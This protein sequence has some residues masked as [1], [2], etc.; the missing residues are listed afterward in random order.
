MNKTLLTLAF[1][2]VQFTCF[3]QA[4]VIQWKKCFG[5][6]YYDYGNSILPTPDGSYVGVGYFNSINGDVFGNHDLADF[7]IIKLSSTGTI[8]WE[9]TFGGS[10]GD[11][12]YGIQQTSDGGYIVAGFTGSNDGDVTGYHDGDGGDVW[13][14]KLSAIGD[15]IWQKS[16]GGTGNDYVT[17]ILTTSNGD[18]LVAG[19]TFSNDGDVSGNHG[20]SDCWVV[21]LSAVGDVMWQKTLGGSS[22]D[23]AYSIKPTQDG[24][25]IVAGSTLSFDGEVTGNHG[26][27]GEDAWIVKL[28]A[29]GTLVWQKTLG[30]T[31]ADTIY[32]IQTNSDGSFILAGYTI[33]NDGDVVGNHGSTDA[34]VVQL[35]G[36]G[37]LLWQKTLGGTDI[38]WANNIQLTPDGG[39]I[40]SCDA[41]STNGDVTGA[42]GEKDAWLVKLASNGSIMWQKA[43]GGTSMDGAQSVHC[44]SDGGYVFVGAS[45]SLNGNVSGNH[46][47]ADFWVVKLSADLSFNGFE[48][49]HVL[50]YPNPSH[51]ILNIQPSNNTVIDKITITDLMGKLMLM[52]NSNTT[53]VN[54]EQLASGMY[55]LE[56]VS[57]EDKFT[58]KFVKE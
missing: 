20:G 56:A 53:Q 58:C 4:P 6:M 28:S 31:N 14:I 27:S 1:V 30:G 52:Q 42:H 46:G 49:G 25:F 3:A 37:T 44:T 51:S 57:G 7:W 16:L 47:Y 54:I 26:G 9:R 55:M 34:W 48:M 22:D 23:S 15:L 45:T 12:A 43:F 2:L 24:G 40:V 8:I 21:K 17:S 38:E 35:S 11:Y 19:T 32:D 33:S 10:S 29:T 50:T 41:Y 5:G 13:V 39:F 18:F 36:T